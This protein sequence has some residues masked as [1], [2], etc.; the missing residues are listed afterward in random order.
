MSATCSK[1]GV[2]ANN[3]RSV[4]IPPGVVLC[5]DCFDEYT[6]ECDCCRNRIALPDVDGGQIGG[7][8]PLEFE[9]WCEACCTEKVAQCDECGCDDLIADMTSTADGRLCEQCAAGYGPSS[10]DDDAP[11]LTRANWKDAVLQAI[12]QL[13]PDIQTSVGHSFKSENCIVVTVAC[14]PMTEEDGESCVNHVKVRWWNTRREELES[15]IRESPGCGVEGYIELETQRG[16]I[17]KPS[18]S[19]EPG[20][21]SGPIGGL[22]PGSG[23]VKMLE[24]MVQMAILEEMVEGGGISIVSKDAKGRFVRDDE[25]YVL[26]W[27]R[28]KRK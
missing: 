7:C 15:Y 22:I 23:T 12:T 21:A 19:I 14:E 25:S 20:G 4:D 10:S 27:Q 6:W 24:G 9:H 2:I 5:R 3:H 16:L 1:C 11:V 8:T 26:D 17:D 13:P 18:I 28:P